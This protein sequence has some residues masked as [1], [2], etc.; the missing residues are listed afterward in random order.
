MDGYVV[1]IEVMGNEHTPLS[2]RIDDP[3]I[4]EHLDT[5]LDKLT[6]LGGSV[7]GDGRGWSA[8]VTVDADSVGAARR[9][10]VPEVIAAATV[11]GLPTDPL[12]RVEVVRED[13][14][15]AELELP[16][17]PDIVSGAE[18][19]KILNVTRQRLHQLAEAHKEFPTP[20]YQLG[21]GNLYM[22]SAIEKFARE[23]NRQPG[24]PPA[25]VRGAK[26]KTPDPAKEKTGRKT[27]RR[28]VAA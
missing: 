18:A 9:A 7:S 1:T 21:V 14:R 19:A 24:R 16:T 10:A 15:D 4:Y 26:V 20:V 22:R 25:A 2:P 28:R 13:I 17:L 5:F 12:V 23:W 3:E 27:T 11:A 8:T 6:E